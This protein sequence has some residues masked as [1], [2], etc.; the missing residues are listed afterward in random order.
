MVTGGLRVAPGCE[1]DGGYLMRA[2][3]AAIRRARGRG[4]RHRALGAC[5]AA[6]GLAT[7]LAACGP[8]SSATSGSPPGLGSGNTATYA[9]QPGG[10]ASY[11][12]PFMAGIYNSDLS[13][14][15][16]NDFQYLLYRPLYWFGSGAT[17]YLNPALSLAFPPVYRGHQVSIRLKQNYK[18]SNEEPVD[19]QNVVFWMNMMIAE[20]SAGAVWSPKGLPSDVTNIRAASKYVVTMDITT[21]QF[22]E[23]WFTNN[24]LSIITPM[25]EAWDRTATGH[26]NCSTSVSNCTA[27]YKYLNSQAIKSPTTFA[28]SPIWSVVNGPWKIQSLTSQG[29]LTL[30][31]N[32]QYGG[33]VVPHHVTTFVELPFTSEQAEYNVLQ[34]PN[35]SQTIDVGY[36]PT[37]DAPV[38]PAG[39][40]VGANPS[41]LSSYQLSVLYAWELSYFPYNFT[42]NNGQGAIFKQLYFRRAF[43]QLVDQEGVIAGPLHGYG[44]PTIGPVG[45]YPSTKYLSPQLRTKGDQWTLNIPAAQQLLKAHGWTVTPNGTDTCFRAG[46]AANACGAGIAQGAHLKLTLEYATGIDWIESAARELASNAS[47]AG[48]QV[49]LQAQSFGNVIN[50]AIG[51]NGKGWGM[52][53]WGQWTYAPDYLPTGD[54][55]FETG[56]P[57]NLGFYNDPHNDQLILAT[58]HARTSA[59]FDLAMYN[60]QNYVASQLPVVYEPDAPT[61]LETIRGLHIGVQN[62]ALNIT[63]EEWFY[64]Q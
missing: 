46:T 44:K 29:K 39:A 19:A 37:V 1:K 64:R 10:Y 57:N 33:P 14:Y 6:A 22:S 43:Q 53:D 20:G 21:P 34:D 38:P 7:V 8:A 28:S 35:G 58:L 24:E 47:L 31:Y 2:A 60:W 36:L 16:V 17:P 26:S 63:P 25:P 55:L 51:T 48:I 41:S 45:T 61:L 11:P 13:I 56:A 52:T 4:L 30:T 5:C 27:V 12:F 59:Q 3:L 15:N 62:S 50:T 49:N 18:W 9:M 23:S 32:S 40:T 54:T 42:N